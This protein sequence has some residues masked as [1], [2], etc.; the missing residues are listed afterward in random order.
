MHILM[1]ENNLF[2]RLSDEEAEYATKCDPIV[3]PA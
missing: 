1:R 2:D 3:Q